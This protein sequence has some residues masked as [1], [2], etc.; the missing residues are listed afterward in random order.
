MLPSADCAHTHT[1]RERESSASDVEKPTLFL[2]GRSRRRRRGE[3]PLTG[4]SELLSRPAADASSLGE[5]EGL[6]S[7]RDAVFGRLK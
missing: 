4:C 1:E 5:S 2:W 7:E 6:S 3:T